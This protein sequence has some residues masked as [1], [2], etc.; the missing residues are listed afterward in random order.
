MLYQPHLFDKTITV[1]REMS[2]GTIVKLVIRP[3]AD[4]KVEILQYFKKKSNQ[5]KFKR[6]ADEEGKTVEFKK[7]GLRQ[8]YDY[9]FG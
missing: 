1:E 9:L 4:S 7:L 2:T 6:V 5:D 3:I 8:S